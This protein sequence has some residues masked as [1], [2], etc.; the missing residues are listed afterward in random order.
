MRPFSPAVSMLLFAILTPSLAPAQEKTID[1]FKNYVRG[2]LQG[3]GEAELSKIAEAV[4]KNGDGKISDDEF[5]KRMQAIGQV[6]SGARPSPGQNPSTEK[7]TEPVTRHEVVEIEPLVDSQDAPVLLITG[8][9]LAEAW[10]P[11]AKWKTANGKL[12][13]IVTVGQIR[14]QF[15]ADSI[16]EK[17]RLCVRKHIDEHSTQWV[18]LGG[19][20]LPGGKGLVP[21]GHTTV[22]RQERSGIPTDIVYIS[23]TNWDADGDGIYGEFKDDREAITY[24]D[25][26]V[27]LGRI[28]V[29]T[30]ED[31]AAFTEKVI[32]YESNYPTDQFAGNMI[33]TCTDQPAYPKVRNSWDGYLSGVWNGKMGR[34]F[35]KETPWDEEGKPGSYPLS[36][37]NLVALIN[38][39][40][41]GKMHIHGHGHLPAWVLERSTF[42]SKHIGQLKNDGAYPLITTVSCNT[43]EYDSASDPSI[44]EHMLRTPKAGSVAVVAPIRTGKAH[45][46]K[47][48]DFRLMV[49][50]GKLDGTTM[51]MTRYWT[52][53]LGN[54]KTTGQAIMTAKYEMAKDAAASESYHL[55]VCELNL[56]G[57][58]TLDM[59]ANA[60]KSPQLSV[61]ADSAGDN[62]DVT[63]ATNAPG[64]TVCLWSDDVYEIATADD[65]GSA[66]FVIASASGSEL[67]VTA[68]GASLNSAS[69]TIKLP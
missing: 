34:F 48:S 64:C 50:E 66:K 9:E 47:S 29:R 49:T 65:S 4:D 39:K 63:V 31:V 18:I 38:R 32:A 2:K 7:K 44:V 26:S 69:K 51:T 6:M 53:G 14:E 3:L 16:Q 8:D 17:I 21:G 19:D 58:P 1:E 62:T 22:H 36:A 55:C 61:E 11:F 33:Y 42:T 45:F 60:P 43:G 41:T 12:T 15:E 10:V 20:C 52:Q 5:S 68:T 40:D 59:R 25:G 23:P 46:A 37:E 13:K 56:L 67:K 24:P 28:P 30:K 35:S 27:G 54:G 57:D